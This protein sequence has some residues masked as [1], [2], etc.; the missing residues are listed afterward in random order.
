MRTVKF[1]VEFDDD[2]GNNS[3]VD[4]QEWVEEVTD[5]IN[6]L[7]RVA[8][9]EA[10][11]YDSGIR[12]CERCGDQVTILNRSD[13]CLACES[14]PRCRECDGDLGEIDGRAKYDGMCSSCVHDAERSGD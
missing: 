3:T 2:G 6:D 5:A 13:E 11:G 1:T 12:E 9:V 4:M 8:G 10:D 14:I 7:A